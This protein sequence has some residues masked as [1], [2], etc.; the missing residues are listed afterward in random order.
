MNKFKIHNIVSKYSNYKIIQHSSSNSV[1][2]SNSKIIMLN[3]KNTITNLFLE[4]SIFY[5]NRNIKTF[6]ISNEYNI[7]NFQGITANQDKYWFIEKTHYSLVNKLSGNAISILGA[8]SS[9]IV[10][11]NSYFHG[12]EMTTEKEKYETDFPVYTGIRDS[13][14]EVFA[15]PYLIEKKDN[16]LWTKLYHGLLTK[17]VKIIFDTPTVFD[18]QNKINLIKNLPRNLNRFYINN[19][20]RS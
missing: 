19:S 18:I 7:N 8:V 20:I 17:D 4:N 15:T 6:Y 10:D 5:T 16:F 14:S 9:N 11:G 1:V 2:D 3:N 12:Y 13:V